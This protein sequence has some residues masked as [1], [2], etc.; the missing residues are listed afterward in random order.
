MGFDHLHLMFDRLAKGMSCYYFTTVRVKLKPPAAPQSFYMECK[1]AVGP[2]YKGGIYPHSEVGE[3]FVRRNQGH[4]P[5][6]VQY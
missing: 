1:T 2:S 6:A 4:N 3:C 5:Y